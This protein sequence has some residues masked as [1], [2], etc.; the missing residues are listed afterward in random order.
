MFREISTLWC[1]S[2]HDATVLPS[3]LTSLHLNLSNRFEW[4]SFLQVRPDIYAC[5]SDDE[6][7]GQ[8]PWTPESSN[9]SESPN[10]AS[11]LSPPNRASCL[12][13]PNRGS[14]FPLSI[15]IYLYPMMA[16]GTS[17]WRPESSNQSDQLS[18]SRAPLSPNPIQSILH[19]SIIPSN[20]FPMAVLSLGQ[21]GA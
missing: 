2:R 11:R 14:R 4:F 10:R 3:L 13:L 1:A 6:L 8:A 18:R 21:S 7:K 19:L 16:E 12:S 15:L 5:I 17:P 20:S 9:H